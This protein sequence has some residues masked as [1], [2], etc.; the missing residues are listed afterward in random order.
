MASEAKVSTSPVWTEDSA[1]A[2]RTL[3]VHSFLTPADC[4]CSQVQYLK[5]LFAS[6]GKMES[7]MVRWTDVCQPISLSHELWGVINTAGLWKQVAQIIFLHSLTHRLRDSCV[8]LKLGPLFHVEKSQLEWLRRLGFPC[9]DD[10]KPAGRLNRVS[11]C[12]SGSTRRN[13]ERILWK[14]HL[15]IPD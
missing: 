11:W 4:R 8:W 12:D 9:P 10:G 2:N 1:K 6:G 15:A 3:A 7:Q 13:W 14:V 5:F